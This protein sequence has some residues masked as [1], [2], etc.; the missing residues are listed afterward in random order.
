MATRRQS[1]PVERFDPELARQADNTRVP[2]VPIEGVAQTGNLNRETEQQGVPVQPVATVE[3]STG[4]PING[5]RSAPKG[6]LK[7]SSAASKKPRGGDDYPCF[8]SY[9][10]ATRESDRVLQELALKIVG[11]ILKVSFSGDKIHLVYASENFLVEHVR[12]IAG[13]KLPKTFILD[14]WHSSNFSLARA[15]TERCCICLDALDTSPWLK[16]C[17]VCNVDI[18]TKCITEHIAFNHSVCPGCRAPLKL[19]GLDR[20]GE[21]GTVAIPPRPATPSIPEFN[22]TGPVFRG[23][24]DPDPI[25]DGPAIAQALVE[26]NGDDQDE[27]GSEAETHISGDDSF[28]WTEDEAA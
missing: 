17:T 15:S 22:P 28:L 18:H 20:T 13:F 23:P 21:V 11:T 9:A 3:A 25:M 8:A 26:L 1:R 16:A 14:A 10:E 6:I 5:K 19:F 2:R 27:A 7:T 12:K 24:Q 4:G